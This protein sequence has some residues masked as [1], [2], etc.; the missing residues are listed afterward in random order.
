[1]L[2][3]LHA[4][5]NGVVTSEVLA[6]KPGPFAPKA[7]GDTLGLLLVQG[8]VRKTVTHAGKALTELL[9][10]SDVLLPWGPPIEGAQQQPKRQRPGAEAHDLPHVLD[11]PGRR[12]A[13]AEGEGC[14]ESAGGMPAPVAE[15]EHHE[16]RADAERTEHDRV[17]GPG[18][19]L[20]ERAPVVA[21]AA[22]LGH[23]HPGAERRSRAGQDDAPDAGVVGQAPLVRQ[24]DP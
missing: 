24:C 20:D 15:E 16:E 23:V 11:A 13:E 9:V 14:D 1:M 7:Q 4:V 5:P 21:V 10:P 12:G 8:L 18:A 3:S 6:Y 19:C 17:E 2:L 22:E